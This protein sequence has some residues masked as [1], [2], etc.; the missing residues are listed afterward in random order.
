MQEVTSAANALEAADG[1]LHLTRPPARLTNMPYDVLASIGSA[2]S[3]ADARRLRGASRA[4]REAVGETA[5]ESA[6]RRETAALARSQAKIR[7]QIVGIDT[8]MWTDGQP[9]LLRVGDGYNQA[10]DAWGLVQSLG[11]LTKGV[12][13]GTVPRPARAGQSL[14]VTVATIPPPA[15]SLGTHLVFGILTGRPHSNVNAP[16]PPVSAFKVSM[17]YGGRRAEMSIRQELGPEGR[18]PWVSIIGAQ[19]G[20]PSQSAMHLMMLIKVLEIAGRLEPRLKVPAARPGAV[21]YS[22]TQPKPHI[23]GLLKRKFGAVYKP[24]GRDQEQW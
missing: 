1:L 9:H 2:V 18:K 12:L 17:G 20:T 4:L 21:L 13:E 15:K 16:L 11:R 19:H 8:G 7:Y 10:V 23:V 22:T 24:S 3:R 5:A 6:A 14:T